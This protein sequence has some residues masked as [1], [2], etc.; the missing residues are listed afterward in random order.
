VN[1]K[2]PVFLEKSFAAVSPLARRDLRKR[3]PIGSKWI[4]WHGIFSFD[5]KILPKEL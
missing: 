2:A 5:R 1:E 3:F 4:E